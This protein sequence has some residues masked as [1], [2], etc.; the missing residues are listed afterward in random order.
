M[1][2]PHTPRP[3]AG[4]RRSSYCNGAA[5]CVEVTHTHVDDTHLVLVRDA[6]EQD[7]PILFFTPEEWAAFTAGVRAGEFDAPRLAGE[8]S[9]S[10]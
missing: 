6:K 9:C 8:A 10:R 4:W 7:G 1:T 2:R 5:A 3:A